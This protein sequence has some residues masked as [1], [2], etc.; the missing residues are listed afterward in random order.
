[1]A[2]TCVQFILWMLLKMKNRTDIEK[3]KEQQSISQNYQEIANLDAK[4]KQREGVVVTPTQVV[5]FQIKSVIDKIKSQGYEIDEVEWADP[6]GGSGIYT[7]RLL[8]ICELSPM[9][10]AKLASNCVVIEIDPVAAQ[11]CADNLAK[12]YFE[13]TGCTNTFTIEPDV[14]LWY[15]RLPL[16]LPKC[17]E[18]DLDRWCTVMRGNQLY[19]RKHGITDVALIHFREPYPDY[20]INKTDIFFYIYGLLHSP[21]YQKKWA[22]NLTK[23]LPRIPRMKTFEDFTEFKNAGRQLAYIHLKYESIKQYPATIEVIGK[24]FDQLNDDDFYVKNMK[25]GKNN[26]GSKDLT[27]IIYNEKIKVKNIPIE[28][29]EYEAGTKTGIGWVMDRQSISIHKDSGIVND[30]NDWA[31][32]TMGNPRYPLELLLRVITVSLETMKIVK[33]LPKMDIFNG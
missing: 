33:N 27:T 15:E 25:F 9:R 24:S 1:M 32:E 2:G 23:E 6:F 3:A 21:E 29:Y 12:V 13:E 30:A 16:I 7:A 14:N 5:D 31:I 11:I 18:N 4:R 17:V 22:N 20:H 10:K 8:Q 28:A 19:Q 26:D